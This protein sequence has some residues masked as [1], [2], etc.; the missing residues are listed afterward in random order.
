MSWCDSSSNLWIYPLWLNSP[1]N[2]APPSAF[3]LILN[4]AFLCFYLPIVDRTQGRPPEPEAVSWPAV[5]RI[6]PARAPPRLERRWFWWPSRIELISLAGRRRN[7]WFCKTAATFGGAAK[8]GPPWRPVLSSGKIY[9]FEKLNHF[10]K[11][12]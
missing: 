4:R 8:F 12:E 7:T 1:L 3:F 10:E 11:G 9:I 6:L 5:P 2:L